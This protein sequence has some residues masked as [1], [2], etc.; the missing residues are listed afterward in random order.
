LR[1][2][3]LESEASAHTVL[4]SWWWPATMTHSFFRSKRPALVCWSHMLVKCL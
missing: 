1:W 2:R 3:L 4:F